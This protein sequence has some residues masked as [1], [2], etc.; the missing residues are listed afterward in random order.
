MNAKTYENLLFICKNGYAP[1]SLKGKEH[2]IERGNLMRKRFMYTVRND[3]LYY[4]KTDYVETPVQ[5]PDAPPL[6]LNEEAKENVHFKIV[7]TKVTTELEQIHEKDLKSILEKF[8]DDPL[9]GGH[10]G[11]DKMK[12]A[13][14]RHYYDKHLNKYIVQHINECAVCKKWKRNF[15]TVPLQP[16]VVSKPLERMM[17]DFTQ[18]EPDSYGNSYLL[19]MI[20]SFTKFIWG[21][22]FP[23]KDAEHVANF[24]MG[25]FLNE[26]F[27][28]SLQNDNGGEFIGDVVKRLL[29]MCAVKQIRIAAYHP[30][31]DGQIERPNATIKKKLGCMVEQTHLAWSVCLPVVIAQY[32]NSVHSTTGVTPFEALRP[33]R[34]SAGFNSLRSEDLAV[35]RAFLYSQI[36]KKTAR[37]AQKMIERHAKKCKVTKYDI[38]DIVLVSNP[39]EKRKKES[40]WIPQ[41]RFE[42]EI[43]EV[44]KNFTYR[45]RWR[46][47]DTPDNVGK[48]NLSK[49]CWSG[50]YFKILSKNKTPIR[51][52]INKPKRKRRRVI[53][54]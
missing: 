49:R 48:D 4:V 9:F 31:S 54:Q 17:I 20:D 27:P 1:D 22:A 10:Q 13:I 34:S 15:T 7:R 19:L 38:G 51:S 40:K 36:Q 32:N 28:E 18:L 41:F 25:I 2:R 8:H 30:Q 5:I 44:K 26:G 45:L 14:S 12:E 35:H 47:D 11:R 29:E 52:R 24:V 53:N 16:I 39:P 21:N 6:A 23:S 42:G 3:K 50:K 37:A 46:S 43:V 33:G